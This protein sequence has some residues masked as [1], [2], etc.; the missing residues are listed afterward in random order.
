MMEILDMETVRWYYIPYLKRG[1]VL[2]TNLY[3]RCWGECESGLIPHPLH[4]YKGATN[5]MMGSGQSTAGGRLW[6]SLPCP[7]VH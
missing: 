7:K 3:E 4:M 2:G 6:I 1:N 5:H